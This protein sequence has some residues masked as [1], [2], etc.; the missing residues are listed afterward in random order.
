MLAMG[1][2]DEE[3][4]QFIRFSFD[5]AVKKDQIIESAGILADILNEHLEHV[6][7]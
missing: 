3:A 7:M 5:P 6:N 1:Y 2:N 4:K